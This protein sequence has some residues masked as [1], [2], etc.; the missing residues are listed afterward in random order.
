MKAN[1]K[2]T[3]FLIG[4]LIVLYMGFLGAWKNGYRIIRPNDK[5][6]DRVEFNGQQT[7]YHK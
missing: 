1:K 2:F 4:M 3:T 5:E 6:D 7:L